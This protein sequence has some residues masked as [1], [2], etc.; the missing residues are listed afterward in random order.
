MSLVQDAGLFTRRVSAAPISGNIDNPEGGLDALMQVN[1]KSYMQPSRGYDITQ[2]RR[3]PVTSLFQVMVCGNKI[4]WR[5]ESRRVV[6]YTTDQVNININGNGRYQII[7]QR[8]ISPPLKCIKSLLVPKW[9][10]HRMGNTLFEQMLT[11][12]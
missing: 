3:Y 11:S 8:E 7:N 12:T 1:I 5:Q 6:V 4:G 10:L 2:V 9:S